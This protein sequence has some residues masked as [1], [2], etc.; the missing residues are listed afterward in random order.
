MQPSTS[1][2]TT[3]I[4]SRRIDRWPLREG[5]QHRALGN[6]EVTYTFSEKVARGAF[7]AVHTVPE[8]NHV[9]VEL[10]DLVLRQR[11]FQ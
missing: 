11:L 10:E 3:W 4:L 1:D 5:R 8:I 6:G 2:R 7:N 9:Q